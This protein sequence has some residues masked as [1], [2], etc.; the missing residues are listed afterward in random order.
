MRLEFLVATQE[1][2]MRRITQGQH[3]QKVRQTPSLQISQI[4]WCTT[5]TTAMTIDRRIIAV[6]AGP[7]KKQETLFP[8]Q[9]KQKRPGGMTQVVKHLPTKSKTL[10]SNPST[11]KKTNG[12]LS[13]YR[14]CINAQKAAGSCLFLL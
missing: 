10:S 4:W 2:E 8:K 7:M 3:R 5:V 6:Q 14:L 1:M 12:A 13:L 11:T 9:L